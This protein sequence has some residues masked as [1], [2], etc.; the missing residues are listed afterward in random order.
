MIR[1]YADGAFDDEEAAGETEIDDSARR[2]Q[3]EYGDEETP[4]DGE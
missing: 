2:L 1:L 3:D 4:A